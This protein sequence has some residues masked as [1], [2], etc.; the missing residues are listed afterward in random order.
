MIDKSSIKILVV[1]DDPL[2]GKVYQSKLTKEGYRVTLVNNGKEAVEKA[3]QEKPDLVLMDII[4]PVMDGFEALKAIKDD[5][6]TKNIKVIM[7]TNLSQGN[8]MQKA[9]ELGASEY[10]VK[11]DISIIDLVEKVNRLFE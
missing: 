7:M 9:K 4:M 10:L 2:Y 1:E 3:K 6:N 11:S 8:D 5:N